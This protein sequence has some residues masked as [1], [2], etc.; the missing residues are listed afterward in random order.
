MM[1]PCDGM[2][3]T[4]PA[5]FDHRRSCRASTFLSLTI[6]RLTTRGTWGCLTPKPNSRAITLAPRPR[7][8]RT[9]AMTS[10]TMSVVPP[11]RRTTSAA[12]ASLAPATVTKSTSLSPRISSVESTGTASLDLVLGAGRAED[13]ELR[14]A[15]LPR[16]GVEPVVAVGDDQERRLAHRFDLAHRGFVEGDGAEDRASVAA[17]ADHR[18]PPREVAERH[19]DFALDRDDALVH[20]LHPPARQD[21]PFVIQFRHGEARTRQMWI[22]FP[23]TAIAASLSASLVRRVGVAGVGDVFAGRAELHRQR[24]FGDHRARRP[25]R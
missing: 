3:R 5:I 15:L 25:R 24:R 7:G 23:V 9:L 21:F 2:I 19:R 6:A 14:V 11:L 20:G 16:G 10:L 8:W 13:L 1:S 18:H 4:S 12:S 17:E 22:G